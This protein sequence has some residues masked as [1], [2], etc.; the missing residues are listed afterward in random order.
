MNCFTLELLSMLSRGKKSS[1]FQFKTV[2]F[3]Y[4]ISLWTFHVRSRFISPWLKQITVNFVCIHCTIFL[5][6]SCRL[7]SVSLFFDRLM[8]NFLMIYNPM[9]LTSIRICCAH[10]FRHSSGIY[11]SLCLSSQKMCLTINILQ[12][13]YYL[14]KR[15]LNAFSFGLYSVLI[16]INWLWHI[17]LALNLPAVSQTHTYDFNSWN[18]RKD[19]CKLENLNKNTNTNIEHTYMYK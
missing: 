8:T 3:F 17:L 1:D 16:F 10:F 5:S 12:S 4:R 13:E 9:N 11:P 2:R 15:E 14:M 7:S 19:K 18:Q 6:L